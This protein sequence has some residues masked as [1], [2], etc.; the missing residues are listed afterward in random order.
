MTLTT[1]AGLAAIAHHSHALAAA[2]R[3][4]L[5]APVA[6]CPG[7]DVADLVHHVTEVHWFWGTIVAERL[8]GP[9]AEERRP[10]RVPPA[11]L[12]DHFLVGADRLVATLRD[13][14]Q[15]TPVWTWFP[16]RQ[17]VGFVTRHQV[18]EAAVHHWDAADAVGADWSM[19][20]T[21]AADAVEEF[22]TCSL[23]DDDDVVR[24]GGTLPR[25][26]TLAATDTGEAWTVS[27]RTPGSGLTWSAGSPG[28]ATVTG[29]A[30]DLLLWIYQRVEL[31]VAD[32]GVVDAFRRLSSTD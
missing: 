14:D 20:P 16:G 1:E 30:A 27:Q 4:D 23:A 7:W 28:A 21:S 8:A 29:S 10:G 25:P 13:A 31:P 15:A 19:D 32:Q 9:V 18:Q 22:L 3:T 5:A 2:A 12:V 6:H 24:I 26:L 17:D 11:E